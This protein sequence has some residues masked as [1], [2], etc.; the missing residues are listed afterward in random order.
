MEQHSS[1][2][3]LNKS[4]IDSKFVSSD[5]HDSSTNDEY[6]QGDSSIKANE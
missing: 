5:P 3:K 6:G 4:R 2:P 1:L